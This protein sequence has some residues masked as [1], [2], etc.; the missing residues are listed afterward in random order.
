M[1][2]IVSYVDEI[3]PSYEQR[4]NHVYILNSPKRGGSAM[5]TPIRGSIIGKSLDCY[6]SVADWHLVLLLQKFCRK[7]RSLAIDTMRI[8]RQS[9]K[10]TRIDARPNQRRSFSTGNLRG[11]ATRTSWY[12][13]IKTIGIGSRSPKS[14]TSETMRTEMP[15]N[16]FELSSSNQTDDYF[17]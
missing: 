14:M 17:N 2:P 10:L 6:L 15:T 11:Q 13:T 16:W 1:E 12:M 4:P 7:L 8:Y 9:R 3:P 5:S